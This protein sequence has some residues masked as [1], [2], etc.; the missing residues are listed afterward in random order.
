MKVFSATPVV[1]SVDAFQY[2]I[3]A[4]RSKLVQT[5]HPMPVTVETQEK[6]RVSPEYPVVER[7][8]S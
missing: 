7:D 5:L 8:R 6:T 1:Q 2:C 4:N 3:A